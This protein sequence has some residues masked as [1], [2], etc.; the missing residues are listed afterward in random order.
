MFKRVVCVDW[1]GA[2]RDDQ[3]VDLRIVESQPQ[4]TPSVVKAPK[5]RRRWSR[6]ECGAFLTEALRSDQPRTLIAVDFGLGLPWGTDEALFDCRGWR[7]LVERLSAIYSECGTARKTAKEINVLPRF[8]GHGPFR[9]NDS[10]TDYRFYV[11]HGVSYYRLVDQCVPQAISHWYLGSG[12]TVGFHTISGLATVAQ[13]LQERDK[14]RVDFRVWPQEGAQVDQSRHVMAEIY[15]AVFRVPEDLP[16][17]LDGHETDAWR[18]AIAI[19]DADQA[20]ELD[21]WF[22]IRPPKFG[23]V[24]GVPVDTQVAFEGWILGVP[25][26]I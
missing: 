18:A 22:E 7:A 6:E 19:S 14:G 10:R 2:N 12:G 24:D 20:N 17:D 4:E 1:S 3:K 8:D 21:K 23:R 25:H 26:Y 11:D 5:G 15:P 9:F 16:G 13:L